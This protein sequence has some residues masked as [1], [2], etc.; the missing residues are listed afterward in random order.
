MI[1]TRRRNTKRNRRGA[2]WTEEE[3]ARL[4]A[5]AQLPP[6]RV[7]DLMRRSWLACRRRLIYLRADSGE[8]S[9]SRTLRSLSAR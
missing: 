1:S 6:R 7:A 2:P 3:D 9:D 4:L 5:L 8:A